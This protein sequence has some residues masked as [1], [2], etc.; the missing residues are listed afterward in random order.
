MEGRGHIQ[1]V[2]WEAISFERPGDADD[3]TND[4]R[5]VVLD[6]AAD[7]FPQSFHLTPLRDNRLFLPRLK[8]LLHTLLPTQP[9]LDLNIELTQLLLLCCGLLHERFLPLKQQLPVILQL[10]TRRT[11]IIDARNR[12]IM[13]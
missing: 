13:L 8:D 2:Q 10:L 5:V 12:Q 7:I 3:L 11:L 4:S 1:T 6:Q 9:L